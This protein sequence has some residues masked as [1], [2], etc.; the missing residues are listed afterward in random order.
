MPVD[1]VLL[2][3]IKTRWKRRVKRGGVAVEQRTIEEDSRQR[4]LL[5][6][7]DE[8]Q[9]QESPTSRGTMKH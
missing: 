4:G 7:N 1:E 5:T 6:N 8:H 2:G 3:A 9:M